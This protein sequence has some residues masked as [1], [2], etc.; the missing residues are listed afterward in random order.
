[1]DFTSLWQLSLVATAVSLIVNFIKTR[2]WSWARVQLAVIIFSLV[3][4]SAYYW[5]RLAGWDWKVIGQAASAIV[6]L[7]NGIYSLLI[8]PLTPE[9]S[10]G[11]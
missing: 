6:L 9:W 11:S 8:K 7:A 2:R 3:A 5:T 4:A 1:M 10:K